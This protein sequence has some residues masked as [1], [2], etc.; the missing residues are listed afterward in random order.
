MTFKMNLMHFQKGQ[1]QCLDVSPNW[2][3]GCFQGAKYNLGEQT[4]TLS[5]IHRHP[6]WI[7]F[8]HFLPLH[9][10]N[11]SKSP[12]QSQ[13]IVGRKSPWKMNQTLSCQ[14]WRLHI[15]HLK[16]SPIICFEGWQIPQNMHLWGK[17]ECDVS[18]VSESWGRHNSHPTN[19]PGSP[20]SAVAHAAFCSASHSQAPWNPPHTHC[21]LATSCQN[22]SGRKKHLKAPTTS[23]RKR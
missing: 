16:S 14:G 11:G 4:S 8:C 6:H 22:L 17:Q 10:R 15:W 2:W 1:A 20:F 9:W 12:F 18:S 13:A 7:W 23:G 21:E 19:K 5:S 3:W